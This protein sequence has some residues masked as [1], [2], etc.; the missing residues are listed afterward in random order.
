MQSNIVVA[1]LSGVGVYCIHNIASAIL[2]A[3]KQLFTITALLAALA[4]TANQAVSTLVEIPSRE[5]GLP[6]SQR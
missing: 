4:A 1:V 5:N 6:V 2:P 3:G